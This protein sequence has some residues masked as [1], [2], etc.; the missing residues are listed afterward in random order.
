[1]HRHC[2]INVHAFDRG[3]HEDFIVEISDVCLT[4]LATWRN[5]IYKYSRSRLRITDKT[6]GGHEPGRLIIYTTF[7]R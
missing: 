7:E 5:A 4:P 2:H 3:D 6:L 1:M